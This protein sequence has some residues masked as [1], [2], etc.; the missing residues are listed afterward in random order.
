RRSWPIRVWQTIRAGRFWEPMPRN[1]WDSPLL[2][3]E[4]PSPLFARRGERADLVVSAVP[5]R[6][7]RGRGIEAA[8]TDAGSGFLD[9]GA[10]L[11][12]IC[13][14]WV[15]ATRHVSLDEAQLH[16]LRESARHLTPS[17]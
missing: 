14:G 16:A 10:R 9:G 13:F 12:Q 4:P 2:L 1:S 5:A 8:G 15:T 11:V 17:Q 7:P 3:V 6:L